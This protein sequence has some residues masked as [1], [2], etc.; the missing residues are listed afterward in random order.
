MNDKQDELIY[1]ENSACDG[2]CC[3]SN[4]TVRRLDLGGSSGVFLCK[5]D[6]IKE[7]QWRKERNKELEDFAK[8]DILPW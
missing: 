3:R 6:W 5:Q 7:M 4:V 2:S 8:F 1:I